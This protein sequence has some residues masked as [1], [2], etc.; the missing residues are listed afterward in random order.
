M[1]R[2]F[3]SLLV[4]SVSCGICFEFLARFAAADHFNY[5]WPVEKSRRLSSLFADHRSFRFH[6]GIDIRTDGKTGYKVFACEDGYVYRLFTSYW[7]YGKAIYLRLD[8][9]R[10]AVY[11]HLSNFSEKISQ[12]VEKEQLEKQRYFTDFLLEKDEVRV[13]RGGLIGYSG[14]TGSGGPHLHFEIRDQENHPLNPLTLGYS[15]ED[16][17]PPVI[18]YLAI[19][20]LDIWSRVDAQT[21]ARRGTSDDPLIFRCRYDRGKGAYTLDQMPVIEGRVGLELSVFDQMGGSGFSFGVMGI[22]LFL[23]EELIFASHY[24]TLSYENTQKIELDRDFELRRKLQREFYKLYLD[25][26]NDLSLYTP[27]QGMIEAGTSK[28]DSHQVKIVARDANG[29]SSTLL[30][31]LLFDQTPSIVSCWLQEGE[32]SLRIKANFDDADDFVKKL[33]FEKSASDKIHWERFAQAEFNEPKREYTLSWPKNLDQ[34][35]LLRIKA[36]DTFGASSEYEYILAGRTEIKPPAV[37]KE[38]NETKLDFEYSFKDNFFVFALNF[39][40]ILKKKPQLKLRCGDFEFDPFLIQQVDVKDYRVVFP[41]YLKEPKQMTLLVNGQDSYDDSISFEHVVP[42]SIVTNS[43][44]GEATSEDGKAKVKVD[45]GIVYQDIDLS[46]KRADVSTRSRHKV[47][48]Q[49]Y[50]AEPSTVPLNGHARISLKYPQ[51]DCDPQKLGLYE[52]TQGGWWRSIGQDL[53]TASKTVSGKVRYFSTYAVL[54]DT[55]PPV[56]KRVS[57]RHGRKSKQRRPNIQAVLKDDLSGIAS[58]LD[59]LVTIDGKWMIPEYDPETGL[60]TTR[61]L[62]PLS[63]GKHELVIS[64]KDRAGNREEARRN[65]VVLK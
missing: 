56:I 42:I 29:N 49:I 1:L 48:G 61:P 31:H 63:P 22:Q 3:L 13:E 11:G 60:L 5:V 38:E 33:I 23:D 6:S 39:S 27:G 59:I 19:R 20:P 26:G 54:E 14:Q 18:K 15:V 58:D 17:S 50:T 32:D 16:Q 37:V 51:Q 30:F 12:L 4:L 65:F 57:P 45:P 43:Y 52:L 7:G 2:R 35:S 36:Q 24:D 28:P 8:D 44:G 55:K 62:S 41:F 46:I 21:T 53:D 10:Y 40:Q 9:G 25:V 64:V 47:V 34:P